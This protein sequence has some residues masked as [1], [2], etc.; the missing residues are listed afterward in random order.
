M[1]EWFNT[2]RRVVAVILWLSLPAAIVYWWIIHPFARAW[3]R[4]GPA[5][6]FTIIAIVMAVVGHGCWLIREPV[7]GRSYA[8]QPTLAVLGLALYALAVVIE[9]KCRRHLKLRILVGMPELSSD[10]PGTLLTE[11]IYA[12]TRNPR[13]LDLMIGLA[14][15]SLILNYPGIY[16]LTLGAIVGLYLIVLL[17]ERELR[18]RFGSPYDDYCRSVPRLVPRSWAFLRS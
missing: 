10:G 17:E 13:Y 2:A 3:R 9:R 15:W 14:G 7:L 8:F 4:L 18:E 1:I 12:H 6:T 5:V 16:W 11:G